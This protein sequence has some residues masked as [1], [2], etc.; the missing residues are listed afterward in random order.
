[1][2]AFQ[3]SGPVPGFRTSGFSLVEME[4]PQNGI[5]GN[6]ELGPDAAFWFVRRRKAQLLFSYDQHTGRRLVLDRPRH[7]VAVMCPSLSQIVAHTPVT[8][9][10]EP[11]SGSMVE[12]APVL[13]GILLDA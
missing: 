7:L 1:M 9:V 2:A 11:L 5:I 12:V 8:A 4:F 13:K 10:P 6:F 3:S